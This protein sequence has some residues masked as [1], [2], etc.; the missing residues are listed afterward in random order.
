HPQFK[1]IFHM[2]CSSRRKVMGLWMLLIRTIKV[3]KKRQAWFVV[4]GVPIRYSIREHGLISGLYCHTYPENNESIGSLKFAKKYFQQPPKKKADVL[5]KLKK[6][7]YDGSHERLRMAVL[8]FLATVI[9]QRSRYGTPIDHFLLRMVNDLR[10][11]HTFPWGRFTFDDSLKE[12]KH[13]PFGTFPGFI[14]PLEILAFESI[15]VLKESFREGVEEFDDSCPR[16]CKS[17]FLAN[18]SS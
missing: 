7:K 1:H 12:I 14:N 6:M 9:F 17:R 15:Q 5:K 2:E 13:M 8:Y 3:D 16:M 18:W 4:N 11:C 10:V